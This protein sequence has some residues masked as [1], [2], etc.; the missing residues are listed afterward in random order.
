MLQRCVRLAQYHPGLVDHLRGRCAAVAS[1]DVLADDQVCQ[2]LDGLVV[3]APQEKQFR[4]PQVC[5]ALLRQSRLGIEFREDCVEVLHGCFG[6]LQ[7]ALLDQGIHKLEID[8][9]A[10]RSRT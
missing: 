10:L 8:S 9:D 2:E 7:V 3:M 6:L 4:G 5:Q 1:N